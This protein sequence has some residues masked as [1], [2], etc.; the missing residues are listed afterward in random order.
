MH[1][2]DYGLMI[3]LVVF[4][5][6]SLLKERILRPLVNLDHLAAQLAVLTVAFV[7]LL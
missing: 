5:I 7:R 2:S 4:D 3:L 1:F 6:F